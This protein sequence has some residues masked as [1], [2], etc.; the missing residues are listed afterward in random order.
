MA[1]AVPYFSQWASA[2]RAADILSGALRL[3]DDPRWA[4]SGA[5]DAADYARW[6][7]HVCG[8]ACLKMALAARDG[9]DVPLLELTRGCAAY[10]GYVV[11]GDDIRGLI[12]APFTRFVRERFGIESEVVVD[13]GAA[14]LPAMLRRARFFIASVH[15]AIRRPDDTP[16]RK[17]GHLVLVTAASAD[18]IVFHNPSGHDRAAQIDVALAPPVFDRFFAGRGIAILP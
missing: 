14:D 6:A 4:E 8:M 9:R 3:A 5:A 17:G 10:G 12:Y 16:P 15:P 7:D 11:E 2:D 18:S 13:V 1:S